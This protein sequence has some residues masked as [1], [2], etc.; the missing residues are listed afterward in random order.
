MNTFADPDL[1]QAQQHWDAQFRRLYLRELPYA[2][3][4]ATVA[5]GVSVLVLLYAFPVFEFSAGAGALVLGWL[6]V[7]TLISPLGLV[8]SQL[9]PRPTA[10]WLRKERELVAA[11]RA[12]QEKA[13]LQD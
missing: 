8:F 3:M 5:L 12:L 7:G 13:S 6:V 11:Y 4:A 2:L 10:E 1:L 9:P